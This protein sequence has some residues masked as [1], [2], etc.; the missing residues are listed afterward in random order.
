MTDTLIIAIL[1]G[2]TGA[3]AV[4]IACKIWKHFLERAVAL[5]VFVVIVALVCSFVR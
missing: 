1:G 5:T 4:H 3:T 2:I